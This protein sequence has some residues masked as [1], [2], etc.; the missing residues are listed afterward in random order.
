LPETS[1]VTTDALD[2]VVTAETPEGILLELRPAGLTAR[3]YA[4]IVDWMIRIA[5]L[6]ACRWRRSSPAAPA[7]RCG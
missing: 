7:S 6:Y 2:T 5:V 1:V 3:C 4:F